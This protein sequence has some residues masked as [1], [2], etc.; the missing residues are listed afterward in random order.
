MGKAQRAWGKELGGTAF[1]VRRS[2]SAHGR[3]EG[4]KLRRSEAWGQKAEGMGHGA[5]RLG[6]S[7]LTAKKLHLDLITKN[8][9]HIFPAKHL[10]TLLIEFQ[11]KNTP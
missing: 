9:I 1:G 4:E 10:P 7:Y 11:P 3:K 8:I 5:W 2:A 6:G